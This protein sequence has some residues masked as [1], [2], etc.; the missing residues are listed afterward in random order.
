MKPVHSFPVRVKLLKN[1]RIHLSV[2]ASNQVLIGEPISQ[3]LKLFL[4]LGVAAEMPFGVPSNGL[5]FEVDVAD[6]GPLN[7]NL[8]EIVEIVDELGV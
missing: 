8:S 1:G 6:S 7:M 2:F 5:V 3:P 4:K